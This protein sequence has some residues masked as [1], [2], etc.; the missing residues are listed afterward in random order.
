MFLISNI[1]F[2]SIFIS[3][4]ILVKSPG[5]ISRESKMV[6][7]PSSLNDNDNDNHYCYRYKLI[8]NIGYFLKLT[9]WSQIVMIKNRRTLMIFSLVN[10]SQYLAPFQLHRCTSLFQCCGFHRISRPIKIKHG[11]QTTL[12]QSC[13]RIHPLQTSAPFHLVPFSFLFFPAPG[14]SRLFVR[15]RFSPQTTKPFFF[16]RCSRPSPS[17]SQGKLKAKKKKTKRMFG[18]FSVIK[19]EGSDPVD[20]GLKGGSNGIGLEWRPRGLIQCVFVSESDEV[21]QWWVRWV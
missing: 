19:E 13:S 10:N 3:I 6:N 18:A 16:L 9:I 15:W 14:C 17:P 2:A 4:K 1:L 20:E 7:F 11:Q 8:Q 5:Q 12:T 21:Y